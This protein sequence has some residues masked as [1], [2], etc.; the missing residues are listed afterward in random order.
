MSQFNFSIYRFC[1]K[2]QIKDKKITKEIIK[3][4]KLDASKFFPP[5]LYYGVI[6][7]GLVP[8]FVHVEF[9]P[10][11]QRPYSENNY[12]LLHYETINS[13]FM[14]FK[15]YLDTLGKIILNQCDKYLLPA[16]LVDENLKYCRRATVCTHSSCF[17][18]KKVVLLKRFVFCCKV[19]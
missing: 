19:D 16:L 14:V 11:R 8:L 7:N 13:R 3:K 18:M 17:Y 1:T 15:A 10:D 4:L 9:G 12:G 6:S 5:E 2:L